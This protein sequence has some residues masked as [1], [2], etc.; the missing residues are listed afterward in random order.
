MSTEELHEV[1]EALSWGFVALARATAARESTTRRWWSG[2]REVPLPVAAWLRTLADFHR[3]HP[4]P[5][6]PPY[7]PASD[8]GEDSTEG[9]D[10][11]R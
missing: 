2:A 11:Q 6:P 10:A 4:S 1:G 7:I 3:A 5:V 8:D 9:Q